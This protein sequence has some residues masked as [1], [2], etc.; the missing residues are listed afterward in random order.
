M[1]LVDS[2][3]WIDY[4]NRTVTEPVRRLD[5]LIPAE[6]LLMGDLILCEILQGFRSQAAARLAER[7]LSRFEIVSLC[8]PALAVAA[9]ANDRFLRDRG[10]AIRKLADL[11]I[12]TFCIER[13]HAACCMLIGILSRWSGYLGL[14]TL[15][16][17]E[18]SMDHSY[19]TARVEDQGDGL[20]L[21]TLNRPE[22]ANAL[23]TQMGRDLLAFFDA[24]NARPL[25]AASS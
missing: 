7:S 2:S 15:L 16:A 9:A 17:R 12:G 13:G 1:I 11:L 24:I 14:Q 3:V 6:P 19:E 10:I 23:N 25:I 4:L 21:L 20:V 22:V 8:D 18:K 5:A